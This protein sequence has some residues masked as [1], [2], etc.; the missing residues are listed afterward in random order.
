MR[1]PL[2][3]I[4]AAVLLAFA[5][6]NIAS[7]SPASETRLAPA[8]GA[9]YIISM[10]VHRQPQHGEAVTVIYSVA[11]GDGAV[12]HEGKVRGGAP[13]SDAEA[14]RFALRRATDEVAAILSAGKI[15]ARS[16][17]SH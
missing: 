6:W 4:V 2:S 3:A 1:R 11:K 10:A 12:A 8:K 14:V 5:G 9:D 15:P 7:S 16:M 17:S 13:G